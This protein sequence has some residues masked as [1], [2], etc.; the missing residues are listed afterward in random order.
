[1]VSG[2]NVQLLRIRKAFPRSAVLL[3]IDAYA[4]VGSE[5]AKETESGQ[6]FRIMLNR[7][8]MCAV[9]THSG[10]LEGHGKAQR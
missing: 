4:R 1:M 2:W 3:A 8:S 9:N 10:I 7:T 6:L 5:A